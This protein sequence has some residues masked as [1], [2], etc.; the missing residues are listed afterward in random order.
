MISSIPTRCPHCNAPLTVVNRY[1][2]NIPRTNL[3]AYSCHAEPCKTKARAVRHDSPAVRAA[4]G[5]NGT[6][7]KRTK[8]K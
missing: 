2:I 8:G 4:L 7:G 1:S 3:N 5:G 6:G